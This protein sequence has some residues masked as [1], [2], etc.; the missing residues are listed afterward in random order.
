MNFNGAVK[1]IN[2]CFEYETGSP[3][4]SPSRK[5]PNVASN[6]QAMPAPS[7]FD[8]RFKANSMSRIRAVLV[9]T[10]ISLLS[11]CT[12]DTTRTDLTSIATET[13]QPEP[14]LAY[15]LQPN[16]SDA[17][18][19]IREIVSPGPGKPK[20]E[21]RGRLWGR[22]YFSIQVRPGRHSF[23]VRGGFRET[24]ISKVFESGKTY[25][26]RI[27]APLLGGSSSL[28]VEEISKSEAIPLLHEPFG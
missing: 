13:P 9:G 24:S 22:G 21:L 18:V 2:H 11:A 26:L 15:F 3:P 27:D 14:A 19:T 8:P 7:H 4:C 25:Y 5:S 20:L 1:R 12:S 23:L 6:D 17:I 28:Q 10:L 16:F